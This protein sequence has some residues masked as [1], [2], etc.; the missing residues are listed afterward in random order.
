MYE[1][2][3]YRANALLCL[4]RRELAMRDY[5]ELIRLKPDFALGYYGRALLLR[6]LGDTAKAEADFTKAEK[7]GIKR[8]RE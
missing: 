5:E 6:E 2:Y 3:L 8:L 7:L 4:R 1:G